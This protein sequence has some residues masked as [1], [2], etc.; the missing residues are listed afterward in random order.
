MEAGHNHHLGEEEEEEQQPRVIATEEEFNNIKRQLLD[1]ELTIAARYRALFTLYNLGGE[2]V[3]DA[4][5]LGF[6][7]KS[8]LLKHEI[9][10]VL[11]QMQN[12]Y[13]IPILTHVLEN[14]EENSMVR[15]E[16]GEA[17]GAIGSPESI[18]LLEKYTEDPIQEVAETCSLAIDTIQ[19]K[20]KHGNKKPKTQ[21]DSV[22]PA[23]P[24]TSLGVEELKAKLIDTS[25]PMFKRYRALFALREKC[26]S[27]AVEALTAGFA[28]QSALLRHE[29]AYVLGQM[30]HPAAVE[31]LQKL[32]HQKAEHPMVRHEAAEALG[33]IA[34]EETTPTLHDFCK[35]A[36]AVVRESC[37]VA[38]DISEYVSSD[39]FQYADALVEQRKG[40]AV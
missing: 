36:E 14:R 40:Q 11:G 19:Y 38:L 34:T 26:S 21:F 30:Q 10:Y 4:L 35:D 24:Y 23:P 12:A 17:L 31:A 37:M 28:D 29:I 5:A 25:L 18:P 16:A 8:A 9:A 6:S 32:L 27:E 2:K 1:P 22:D 39:S 33:A 20:I 3:I 7:D 13:A 15:H